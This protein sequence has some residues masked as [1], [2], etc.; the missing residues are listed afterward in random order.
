MRFTSQAWKN[1][2]PIDGFLV[3][4]N[5]LL[6]QN[7]LS[8]D[9]AA[10]QQEGGGVCIEFYT[11]WKHLQTSASNIVNL[12][13][14]I[15]YNN[16]AK[17]RVGGGISVMDWRNSTD[18]L[19]ISS[20][21]FITNVATYGAA[22]SVVAF[23]SYQVGN[24]NTHGVI[25]GPSNRFYDDISTVD[26][27]RILQLVKNFTLDNRKVNVVRSDRF[28]KEV[29]KRVDNFSASLDAL[30]SVIEKVNYDVQYRIE[31]ETTGKGFVYLK[32]VRV[33]VK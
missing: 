18:Y 11:N 16:T 9:T 21:N 17:G 30:L 10:K 6:L 22:I 7:I 29:Q 24:S 14:C 31:F 15:L 20:C 23:P 26:P 3:Y 8:T 27:G 13:Q 5:L 25:L 28:F 32:S 1:S 2:V 19:E 33:A 4:S 12:T